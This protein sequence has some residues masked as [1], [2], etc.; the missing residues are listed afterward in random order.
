MQQKVIPWLAALCLT[1]CATA[2]PEGESSAAQGIMQQQGTQLQ[3]LELLGTQTAGMTLLGFQTSGA[4]L[5]T[6]SLNNVRV[7]SG[8]VVAERN[9]TTLRGAGLAGAHLFAQY[10]NVAADPPKTAL[11]EYRI[12]AVVPEDAAHDPT[13]TGATF[14]YTLEQNVDNTDSWQLACGADDDRRNVAIPLA[15]IW[16][17]HGDRSVTSGLFT[18]GCTTGVVAKCYRWGYRPWV[19]GHGDLAATHWACTRMA[20]GDYCGDGVPHTH[21]GTPINAWD[22]LSPKPIMRH[23]VT[24]LLMLFEAGWNTGGAVCLSRAR[25][26]LDNLGLLANLCPDH[27]IPPGLLLATVCDTVTEVL[28]FDRNARIFNESFLEPLEL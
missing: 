8:E 13:H 26:V 20:R 27:L 10:R 1:G 5:G 23:G 7:E 2:S 18:F 3:G 16:D 9:G 25:W 17:E 22:T 24:P 19:T 12:T 6:A 4:T 15:A 14:L 28:V 21:D 11:V